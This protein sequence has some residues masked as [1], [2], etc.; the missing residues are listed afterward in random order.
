MKTLKVKIAFD[1]DENEYIVMIDEIPQLCGRGDTE[2]EALQRF[3]EQLNIF[4][5]EI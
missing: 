2:S 1:F 3:Q 5:N 4:N